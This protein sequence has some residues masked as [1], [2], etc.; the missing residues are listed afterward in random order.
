MPKLFSEGLI[1]VVAVGLTV[2]FYVFL[3]QTVT[4]F[5]LLRLPVNFYFYG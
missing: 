5:T 3:R 1:K 2:K 4:F